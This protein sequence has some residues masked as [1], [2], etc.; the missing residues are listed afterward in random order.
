MAK[1]SLHDKYVSEDD[2]K[3]NRKNS[4]IMISVIIGVV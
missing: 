2:R 3:R 1:V 4:T